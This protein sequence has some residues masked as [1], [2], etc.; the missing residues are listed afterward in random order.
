MLHYSTH[1]LKMSVQTFEKDSVIAG[2]HIY[3]AIW[4]QSIGEELVV[5]VE[6]DNQYDRYAL[7]VIKK[8][9]NCR[10]CS[11]F[12]VKGVEVLLKS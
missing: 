6:Q 1:H 4:T 3:K 7:S 2:H 8:R 12:F 9:R 10:T 5:E 11:T